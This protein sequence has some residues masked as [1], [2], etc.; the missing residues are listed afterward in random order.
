MFCGRGLRG[1]PYREIP[2]TNLPRVQIHRE[3]DS[4][5]PALR[6]QDKNPMRQQCPVQPRIEANSAL[7]QP[8]SRARSR[9]MASCA[10]I[11]V[12]RPA[13][14]SVSRR[15]ASC[16]HAASISLSMSRL[17]IS[18]SSKCERSTGGKR[19]TSFSRISKATLTTI[20]SLQRLSDKSRQDSARNMR[21]CNPA[22]IGFFNTSTRPERALA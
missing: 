18:R 17:A 7:A 21:H 19:S 11:K 2:P 9:A 3:T 6:W 12:A 1:F 8:A 16:S 15:S 10:G 14:S 22:F 13:A 5:R 20:S 4:R